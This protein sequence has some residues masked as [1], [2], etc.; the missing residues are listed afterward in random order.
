M[1]SFLLLITIYAGSTMAGGDKNQNQHDGE[2]VGVPSN[3]PTG[4]PPWEDPENVPGNNPW[5]DGEEEP[6]FNSLNR[7]ETPK[8]AGTNEN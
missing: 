6:P 7:I 2:P 5:G 3:D 4:N 1:V 8:R